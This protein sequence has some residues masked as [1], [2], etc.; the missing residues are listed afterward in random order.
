M[1]CIRGR[2]ALLTLILTCLLGLGLMATAPVARAQ[3]IYSVTAL[4]VTAGSA[5]QGVAILKQYRDATRKQ[6]GNMGADV[7]QESGRPNRFVVYETWTDQAAFDA[8]DKAAGLTELRDKLK[9]VA[10]VPYDRRA[11]RAIAVA[12]AKP[13]AGPGAVYLQVHLDVLPPGVERTDAAAK[14]LAEAARKGD[15][16]LRYDVLQS[17]RNPGN[18]HTIFAV[19]QSRTDFDAYEMSGS[20]LRFRDVIGPLLGSPYDDRLYALVD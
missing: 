1:T 5:A 3:T 15:G 12:A 13:P 14:V 9:A 8:N 7:L 20:A 2:A 17:T 18:H 6:P 10:D 19:W 4:D 11:Y 16:N